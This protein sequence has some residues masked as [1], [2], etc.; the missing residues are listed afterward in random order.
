MGINLINRVLEGFRFG[1]QIDKYLVLSID[2]KSYLATLNK[3]QLYKLINHIRLLFLSLLVSAEIGAVQIQHELKPEVKSRY[4]EI[5][6]LNRIAN[7]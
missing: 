3:Y 4:F 2:L 5:V 7:R 6:N 1:Y